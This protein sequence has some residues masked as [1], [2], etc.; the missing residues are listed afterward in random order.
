MKVRTLFTAGLLCLHLTSSAQNVISRSVLAIG[1][2]TLN[3]GRNTIE[4]TIGEFAIQTLYA[5]DN[6]IT[7]GFH[8]GDLDATVATS[9]YQKQTFEYLLYP[10]PANSHF[11]IL[12]RDLL[13]YNAHLRLY[14]V[15]GEVIS[16]FQKDIVSGV[17]L[18]ID[19]SSLPSGIYQLNIIDDKSIQVLSQLVIVQH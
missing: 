15:R 13:L 11:F 2:E 1:G 12:I 19:T 18:S 4:F 3:N 8:Q 16:S 6:I 14:N 17:P 7:Q 5:D 10:N 9:E